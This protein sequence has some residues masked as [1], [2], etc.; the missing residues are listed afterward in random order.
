VGDLTSGFYL[1]GGKRPTLFFAAGSFT[2]F[3][4]QLFVR[5]ELFAMLPVI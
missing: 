4:Q 2:S 3:A 1:L 5:K